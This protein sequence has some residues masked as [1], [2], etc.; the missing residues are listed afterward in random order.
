[1]IGVVCRL[2]QHLWCVATVVDRIPCARAN[3]TKMNKTIILTINYNYTTIYHLQ[4]LMAF[5]PHFLTMSHLLGMLA[6]RSRICSI[7]ILSHS[8]CRAVFISSS[9][10]N[11]LRLNLCFI[12]HQMPSIGLRSGLWAGWTRFWIL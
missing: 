6:M 12:I 10:S 4:P 1:M 7:V 2:C 11:N 3:T 8:S 5:P 9:E